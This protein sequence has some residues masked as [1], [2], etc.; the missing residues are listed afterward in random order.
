MENSSPVIIISALS[1]DHVI[2]N[3]TG[4]PWNVPEEYQQYLNFVRGNSVIMGRKSYEIFGNDLQDTRNFV[5]SRNSN[6]SGA[7][8]YTSLE[9]AI[10]KASQIKGPIFIAGGS[11]IYDTAIHLAD[12]MYLSFIRGEFQ[13][14]RY[15]PQIDP[16]QW[17]V[18]E[19]IQH[20]KFIFR[21]FNRRD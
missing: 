4:M 3:D 5:I 8:A 2:G 7:L 1:E 6:F 20:E 16:Q 21:R 9:E 18:V 11:S 15:F 12:I 14:N 17:K 13:G 19:E 10:Q